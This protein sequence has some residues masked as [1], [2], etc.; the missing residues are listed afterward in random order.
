MLQDR[1]YQLQWNYIIQC[2]QYKSYEKTPIHINIY[3]GIFFVV[4]GSLKDDFS[5]IYSAH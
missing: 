3:E 2:K 5:E 4:V 1:L